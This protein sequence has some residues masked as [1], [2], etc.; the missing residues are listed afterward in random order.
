MS[1]ECKKI[2][3]VP[4]TK[5]KNKKKTQANKKTYNNITTE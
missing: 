1:M 5:N 2:V 4:K 3:N